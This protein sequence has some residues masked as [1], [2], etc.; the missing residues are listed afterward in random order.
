MKSLELAEPPQQFQV[1]L[2]LFVTNRINSYQVTL[3]ITCYNIFNMIGNLPGR[4]T[5]RGVIEGTLVG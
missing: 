5:T 2:S 4:V 1:S 3:N